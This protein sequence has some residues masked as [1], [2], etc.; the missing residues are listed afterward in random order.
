M[1]L[2]RRSFLTRSAVCLSALQWLQPVQSYAA[3]AD[4]TGGL[5]ARKFI[6]IDGIRTSYFEAGA[7]ENMVLVHGGH[8]G[9]PTSSAIAWTAI[10]PLLAAHFHVRAVDKLG[11][12][13]TDNPRSDADYS[14]RAV[15]DHIYRFIQRTGIQKIHLVGQSRGGLPVARLAVDHPELVKTLTIIDSNTVAPGDPPPVASDIPAFFVAGGPALNKA[16][17]RERLLSTLYSKE[18]IADEILEQMVEAHLEVALLPKTRQ[19]AERLDLLRSRYV[20]RNRDK[21]LARPALARNSG[22]G[23]WMYQVKD[24]TLDLIEAARLKSPTLIVWGVNDPG[25]PYELG[26]DLFELVRK[27]VSRAQF[28]LFNHCSHWPFVEYPQD[29]TDLLVDFIK[30]S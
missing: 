13:F 4:Q 30:N 26:I 17:I 15:V 29:M 10:F 8:F 16:S 22:T 19:A 5:G 23:W 21:V 9:S 7:G 14:M 25:A 3:A 28:H 2:S 24:E 11:M 20:E 27:S 12:G 18:N 1:T 6:D